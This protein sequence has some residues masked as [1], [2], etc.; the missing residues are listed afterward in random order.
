MTLWTAA[1][2]DVPLYTTDTQAEYGLEL[3]KN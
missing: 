1:K 3:F 2:K